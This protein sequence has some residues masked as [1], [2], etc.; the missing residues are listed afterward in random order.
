MK[1]QSI[2]GALPT[3]QVLQTLAEPAC[4]DEPKLGLGHC[5]AMLM[6]LTVALAGCGAVHW[7][8]T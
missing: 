3:Q 2:D 1:L 5:V 6:Q 4:G 8:M 7:I